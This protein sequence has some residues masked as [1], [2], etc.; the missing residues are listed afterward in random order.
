MC[1]NIF[2]LRY[3][4]VNHANKAT[5]TKT[6]YT[7]SKHSKAKQAKPYNGG[8][9]FKRLEVRACP[10]PRIQRRVIAIQYVDR[11]A[12]CRKHYPIVEQ[13]VILPSQQYS[14]WVA[15]VGELEKE[16]LKKRKKGGG[17]AIT[18]WCASF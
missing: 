14:G 16:S 1:R 8:L 13:R 9:P 11:R 6:V 4:I 12:N 17:G 10:F 15:K 18:W 7:G 2:S 5:K 3:A